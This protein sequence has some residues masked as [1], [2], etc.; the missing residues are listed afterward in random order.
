[1]D[2]NLEG[3]KARNICL[4]FDKINLEKPRSRRSTTIANSKI[5][6]LGLLIVTYFAIENGGLKNGTLTLER[7]ILER[8]ILKRDILGRDTPRERDYQEEFGW[9]YRFLAKR[10]QMLNIHYAQ[11]RKS[12]VFTV[13]RHKK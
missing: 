8:K 1:M 11:D 4:G 10:R 12:V 9:P 7:D 3:E 13:Y 5:R 2:P 6:A